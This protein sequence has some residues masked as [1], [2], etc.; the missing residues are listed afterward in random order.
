MI[1][2]LFFSGKM[3]KSRAEIQKA[4]RERKKQ[5]DPTYKDKERK[6]AAS[7]CVPAAELSSKKRAKRNEKN[8]NIVKLI[9]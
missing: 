2:F 3:A 9:D 6:R 7:Y 5:N 8:R 1:V 4:Y